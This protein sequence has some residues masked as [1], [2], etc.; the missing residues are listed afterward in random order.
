MKS[1]NPKIVLFVNEY[2]KNLRVDTRC[3]FFQI[4]CFVPSPSE[5]TD[6]DWRLFPLFPIISF[7]GTISNFV[8]R[9]LICQLRPDRNGFEAGSIDLSGSDYFMILKHVVSSMKLINGLCIR[10]LELWQVVICWNVRFPFWRAWVFRVS[11][12][13][14]QMECVFSLNRGL[15]CLARV[16]DEL[17]VEAVPDKATHEEVPLMCCILCKHDPSYYLCKHEYL[18]KHYFQAWSLLFHWWDWLKSIMVGGLWCT[19]RER[20]FLRRA[21]IDCMQLSLPP[22]NLSWS[23]FLGVTFKHFFFDTFLVTPLT[24]RCSVLLKLISCLSL[25]PRMWTQIH[26]MIVTEP[27]CF[28]Q[29]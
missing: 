12:R 17:L 13:Q 23:A 3:R 4:G 22:L 8:E 6:Q 14:R 19:P 7:V 24:A 15:N 11:Y 1:H 20:F 21:F 10:M 28:L 5:N 18:S 9:S 2:P 16:S 27:P 26:S 29:C 25:L